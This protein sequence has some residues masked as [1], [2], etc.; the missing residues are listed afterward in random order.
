MRAQKL[1]FSIDRCFQI[2]LL[3]PIATLAIACVGCQST[4]RPPFNQVLPADASSKIQHI[5]VIVQENRSFDN[6]FYGFPGANS[7]SAAQLSTGGTTALQPLPFEGGY[8]LGH[9]L[10]DFQTD[11]NNGAVNG[12]DKDVPSRMLRRELSVHDSRE[13]GVELR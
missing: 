12:F 4:L 8:D 11:W 3:L 6:L 5:V 1:S 2:L 13:C 10:T 9:G 7:T